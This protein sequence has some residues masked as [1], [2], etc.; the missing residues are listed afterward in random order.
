MAS[1]IFQ[2]SM[3][4]DIRDSVTAAAKIAVMKTVELLE[5]KDGVYSTS[6]IHVGI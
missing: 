6:D 3:L 2:D 5:K 4:S 1:L